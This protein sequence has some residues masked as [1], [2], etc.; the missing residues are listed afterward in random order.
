M[1]ITAAKNKNPLYLI[2]DYNSNFNNTNKKTKCYKKQYN[3][4][5]NNE[6]CTSFGHDKSE[7]ISTIN[8]YKDKK[9][10][11]LIKQK[12][13]RK[14]LNSINFMETNPKKSNKNIFKN[15]NCNTQ[16]SFIKISKKI[17]NGKRDINNRRKNFSK[18]IK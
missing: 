7:G 1:D 15:N 16:I 13:K 9:G 10:K 14:D 5:H 6:S 3:S 12:M 18:I 2:T 11:E 8:F 17:N 4:Y